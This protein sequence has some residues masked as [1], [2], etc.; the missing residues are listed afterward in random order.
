M[1]RLPVLAGMMLGALA[2]QAGA[3][4]P[5]FSSRGEL[6]AHPL[7]P[8]RTS[9][10][11]GATRYTVRAG[12]TMTRVAARLGV[13]VATLAAANG[14]ADPNRLRAGQVLSRPRVG[15]PEPAAATTLAPLPSP[16]VVVG[17]GS[18][19]RVSRGENLAR[20]AARYA[21]TTA[22]L[23]SA[24]GLKNPNL[25]RE[26]T[27]LQVPGPPWLCPVQG[28]RQFSDSWGAPRPGGRRHLGVDVFAARGTPVVAS[29]GGRLEHA[30][31]A[32]AGLAYYLR[33]D[34][35]YT[36]YGAHLDALEAQPGRV[37]QGARLGTVGSTGN[38]RGTTPHLHFEIKPGGGPPVNPMPS[39]ERWCRG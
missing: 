5:A 12:D 38:A 4:G 37:E 2:G 15:E 24:N 1:R 9:T 31:G 39:V 29:V 6:R 8:E 22:A 34:D 35:G 23:A 27:E 3:S 25:I 14:I 30:Q 36:Y 32:N 13:S 16:V 7:K 18:R 17:G 26:G 20:I 21:T 10:A 28:P 33:G 19:H 11:Q